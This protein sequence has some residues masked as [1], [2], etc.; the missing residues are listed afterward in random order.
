[1]EEKNSEEDLNSSKFS[2]EEVKVNQELILNPKMSS[3]LPTDNLYEV[4]EKTSANGIYNK[5]D[6]IIY[7][8]KK[9]PISN[10]LLL[11]LNNYYKKA[12]Y[13]KFYKHNLHNRPISIKE[14][15]YQCYICLKKF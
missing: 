11:Y 1:M 13:H 10:C 8:K 5:I 12:K 4:T 15:N 6:K 3:F 14:Q 2:G 9:R 7:N